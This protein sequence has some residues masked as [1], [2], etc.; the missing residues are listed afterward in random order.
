MF[1]KKYCMDYPGNQIRDNVYTAVQFLLTPWSCVI[2]E[3]KLSGWDTQLT[4][5]SLWI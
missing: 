2:L 1:V 4:K 5:N 3:V